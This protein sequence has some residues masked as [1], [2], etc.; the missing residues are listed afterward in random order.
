MNVRHCCVFV[1]L[2]LLA[3]LQPLHADPA[4]VTSGI[5]WYQGD[6]TQAFEAARAENKPVLLYWGAKWCPPCQQLKS[7]IFTRKD[8]I[9]KSRQFV[10]VHLDG[11]DRGA[12]QWGERF[13]ISGYPTLVVLR[14]DQVEITRISGGTDLSSY[15]ELL[16]TALSDVR[17]IKD[18]VT[19]LTVAPAT[20][21]AADCRRLA[22]YPWEEGEYLASDPK[23]LAN[24]LD[25]AAGQC[26]SLS[27]A[28]R[29]RLIIGA[30]TLEPTPANIREVVTIVH[31]RALAPHVVDVLGNLQKPFFTGVRSLGPPISAQFQADWSRAMDEVSNDPMVVDA[32][33]LSA[34]GAKLDVIKQFSAGHSV[35]DDLA[36]NARARVAAA[37]AK[38][39]DP[40]VRTGIVNAASQIYEALDDQDAMF[41]ML[42]A[43]VTTAKAPYYY[44]QDLGE[45]EEHRGHT[46]EALSWYQRAYHDSTGAATRFQW[47]CTYLAALLRLAPHDRGRIRQVGFEVI[48]ELDGPDRIHART[49]RRLEKLD[50]QLRKWNAGHRYNADIRALRLHM[51][52][53]CTKLPSEDSGR[54]SCLHFLS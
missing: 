2:M 18:V 53:E 45:V 19:T 1:A 22:Y 33:R 41:R 20:L 11:D 8:F 50:E 36:G 40:Y 43:E 16:D 47:G 37:L 35:P 44:M 28:E 5:A 23:T 27:T 7:F 34:I 51:R 54:S 52:S 42:Q 17:P 6:I 21:T 39:S 29:A 38:N 13:H 4:A 48:S 26:G 3:G 30:A 14:S 9:D 12:Q 25:S 32:D 46:A 31:D 10:A 49:R 24:A 15:A